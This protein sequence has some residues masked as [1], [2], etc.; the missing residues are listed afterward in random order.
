MAGIL[1]VEDEATVREN[2][3][4]FLEA[5]GYTALQARDGEEG[6]HHR[7]AQEQPRGVAGCEVDAAEQRDIDQRLVHAVLAPVEEAEGHGGPMCS[8]RA[9]F[10]GCQRVARGG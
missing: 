2:I 5:E 10:E 9:Q 7:R 8:R 3:V 6:A 4:E 1:V